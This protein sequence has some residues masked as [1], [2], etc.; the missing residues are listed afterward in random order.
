MMQVDL[1]DKVA[2]VTGSER[3][4]GKAIA[5]LFARNGANVAV[6]DIDDLEGGKTSGEIEAMGRRSVLFVAD[7]AEA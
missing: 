2:L 4:I 5:G 1:H 7:I 6:N 3:G